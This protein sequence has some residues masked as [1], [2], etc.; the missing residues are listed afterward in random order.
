MIDM[1]EKGKKLA[2]ADRLDCLGD[3]MTMIA[4]EMQCRYPA[5][6]CANDR[7]KEMHG[8]ALMAHDWADG[9]RDELKQD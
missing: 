6:H 8:A 2:L 9:I 7:A 5:P 3:T 1:T 4:D